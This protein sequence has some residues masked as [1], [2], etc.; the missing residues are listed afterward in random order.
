MS[1]LAV[2]NIVSLTFYFV[3]AFLIG[4]SINPQ[5]NPKSIFLGVFA[6]WAILMLGVQI[7]HFKFK[8]GQF[9]NRFLT[10]TVF[11]ILAFLALVVFLYY[12]K[13]D[14][15]KPLLLTIVVIHMLGLVIQT[16]FFI[17]QGRE[18]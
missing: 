3:L 15:L 14:N 10:T 6:S 11:Q 8:T 5:V 12:A 9:L 1:K 13:F 18:V 4:W 7:V 16:L 2:Y 17:R